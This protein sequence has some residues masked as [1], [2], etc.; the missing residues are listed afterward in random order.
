MGDF[1][2]FVF[3]FRVF[4]SINMANDCFIAIEMVQ[5]RKNGCRKGDELKLSPVNDFLNFLQMD[6]GT[7]EE[8]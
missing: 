6:E 2:V 3:Y 5:A 7:F 8:L 1:F 4:C